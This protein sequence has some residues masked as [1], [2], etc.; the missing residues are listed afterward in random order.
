MSTST[1]GNHRLDRFAMEDFGT[2]EVPIALRRRARLLAVDL[3]ITPRQA[4]DRLLADAPPPTGKGRKSG[5]TSAEAPLSSRESRVSGNA[6]LRA[7]EELQ[8]HLRQDT[9]RRKK[10]PRRWRPVSGGLPSLGRRR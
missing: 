7:A 3:G 9:R 10:R 6:P 5:Q 2:T 4:L 1:E 8:F